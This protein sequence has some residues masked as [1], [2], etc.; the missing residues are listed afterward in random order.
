MLV[1]DAGKRFG[2]RGG[3]VD[4]PA[5]DLEHG[6]VHQPVCRGREVPQCRRNRVAVA[7]DELA[8]A[9]DLAERPEH[10][11]QIG[12]RGNAHVLAEAKGEIAVS[13]R[14]EDRQ[15]LLEVRASLDEIPRKPFAS[16]RRP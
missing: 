11:R 1:R 4:I 5:D 2:E 8:R 13:L 9:S 6:A 10:D 16:R 12:H 15:R 14:I 7:V 3:A